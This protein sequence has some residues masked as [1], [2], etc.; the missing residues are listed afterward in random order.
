M[1]NADRDKIQKALD[2]AKSYVVAKENRPVVL[3]LILLAVAVIVAALLVSRAGNSPEKVAERFMQALRSGNYAQAYKM[4]DLSKCKG[5]LYGEE[6]FAGYIRQYYGNIQSY[7]IDFQKEY[8]EMQ[9]R[10]S[11][12]IGPQ[13]ARRYSL[14][15]H[16]EFAAVVMANGRQLDLPLVLENLSASKKENW[17]V[18][19]DPFVKS[20]TVRTLPGATVT[21]GETSYTVNKDGSLTLSGFLP[22]KATVAVA[23]A[24]P[25]EVSL[26]QGGGDVSKFAPTDDLRR[27]A[28]STVESFNRAWVQAVR[29]QDVSPIKPYIAENCPVDTGWFSFKINPLKATEETIRDLQSKG[30]TDE[31]ELKQFSVDDVYFANK[32][33]EVVVVARE[34]WHDVKKDK[35]GAVKEDRTNEV[36]WEYHLVK[37][38]GSWKIAYHERAY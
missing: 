10:M 20:A 11:G 22:P 16:R 8:N 9:S 27:Q 21:V 3:V 17:K 38:N 4:L 35:T 19:P 30:L 5:S 15:N 28:E 25:V 6:A 26:W 23:G 31:V 7:R 18:E 37:E 34:T 24:K 13:E 36:K 12:L 32:P 29:T 2:V 33:E 1:E 14:A